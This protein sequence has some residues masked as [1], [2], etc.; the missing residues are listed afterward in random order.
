MFRVFFAPPLL[1]LID[2]SA[3][4]NIHGR[5]CQQPGCDKQP[6]FGRK[7]Y[8]VREERKERE[9]GRVRS[10]RCATTLSWKEGRKEEAVGCNMFF[11]FCDPN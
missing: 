2:R 4:V 6:T 1:F 9:G 8:K 5:R 10:T 11:R 3:M 7:G